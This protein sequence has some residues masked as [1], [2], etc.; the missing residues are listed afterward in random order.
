[1]DFPSPIHERLGNQIMQHGEGAIGDSCHG[2]PSHSISEGGG[3]ATAAFDQAFRAVFSLSLL[4]SLR[5]IWSIHVPR[6]LTQDKLTESVCMKVNF[7]YSY[8]S[9]PRIAPWRA[10]RRFPGK[11]ILYS[12]ISVSNKVETHS[13]EWPKETLKE[14][15]Q[16]N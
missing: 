4:L 11:R 16:R 5:N 2:H 1:M 3:E 6:A 13:G 8:L 14:K 10:V 9:H 12:E 15:K 7:N